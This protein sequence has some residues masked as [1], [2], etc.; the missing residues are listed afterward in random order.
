MFPAERYFYIEIE[1][2]VAVCGY[3]P[4]DKI[5]NDRIL[6]V[7]MEVVGNRVKLLFP[8][9]LICASNPV[10]APVPWL[11]QNAVA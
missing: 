8:G 2:G 7:V 4:Q 11:L 6:A 1:P 3:V 5:K 10:S 9:E